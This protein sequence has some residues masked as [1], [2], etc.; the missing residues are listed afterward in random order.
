MVLFNN[1][2]D[3]KLNDLIEVSYNISGDDTIKVN[4][5]LFPFD[6]KND[7]LVLYRRTQ[8]KLDSRTELKKF[9]ET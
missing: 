1:L 5:K 2:E 9:P 8:Y 6:F 4:D 3:T 7:L